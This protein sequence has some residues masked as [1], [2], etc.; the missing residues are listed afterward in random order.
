MFA[1][2]QDVQIFIM[3]LSRCFHPER[4]ILHHSKTFYFTENKTQLL[5][6]AQLVVER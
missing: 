1:G 5:F 4:T 6:L 2:S 3:P